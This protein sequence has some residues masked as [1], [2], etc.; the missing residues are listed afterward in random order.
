M[1]GHLVDQKVALWG[2]PRLFWCYVDEDFVGVIKRIAVMTK[3]PRSLER[4]LVEKFR[5]FAALHAYAL[6]NGPN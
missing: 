3:D 6:G 1:L 4:V 5:I 2:S